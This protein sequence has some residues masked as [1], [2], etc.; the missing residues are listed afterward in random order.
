MTAPAAPASAAPAA[1]ASRQVPVA[2]V[3]VGALVPGA[4]DAAGYWRIVTGG[5]DMMTEVPAS[6]WLVADHYDPD[7]AAPDKTYARRGAFLPDVG[8]D[9]MAYGVPP[10]SLPSTDTAQL[11]ALMVADQVLTDAGGLPG[12]DRDR[13][14]VVLG[15]SAL[16]L[17]PHMYG[18]TE[19]PVWLKALRESGIGEAEAR[20]VCDRIAAHYT[21][22]RESTFPGL[23]SNVVAG[24]IAHRFDL[25]GTNHTTDAACASSLAALSTAV[26]ELALG[27]ADLVL[28]GGV[29][30]GNGIGMFLSFSKTPAL[31][32]SGDCRPLSD[33]A[34]GTML[35]EAVV[36]YALKRLSDAERDG[37]RVHAVIRGI[38]SSSDG[39]SPGIYAPLPDGQARALRRAYEEAGYGP[40]TVELVEAHGTGTPAGDTAELA[41]LNEVFGA[42]GRTDGQWCAIGSVKSQIGHTKCAAGAAGLLKAVMALH[43]K[44]LPPTIKVGRPNPAAA[45]PDGPFYV[46]TEAR[47]WVR[48]AG[49][50][51]R[52]SVSSFGFGGSNFHVTLEEYVP[53]GPS[54]R[55][56]SARGALG[57][58]AAR[59]RCAPSE[60]VLFSGASPADLVTPDTGD[61]RSLAAL[62][63]ES[64]R[65][66]AATA[67]VRLAIVA[68]DIEE[69]RE[70]H[71]RALALIRR[72]PD[73]AFSVPTGI[74][75]ASGA[76]AP[77][78]IGFLFPGQGSQYVGMGAGLAMLSPAAQSVWD[79]LGGTGFDGL[80]LHR[81]VFPPPSFTDE[82]RADRQTSLAATE[83]AQPAL[84]VHALAL[85]EVVRSLGLRPDCVAGHSFG[86]LVALHC[87]GALD[88]GSL[89]A[90]ARRRGE[91]MRDAAA[92]P[93]AM[94]AV[95]TDRAR[96]AAVLAGGGLGERGR[97]GELDGPGGPGPGAGG[98]WTANHNSPLQT[99]LSGTTEAV[100]RAERVFAAE[101]VATHRLTTSTAFHSPLVAPACEPLAA[102]LRTVPFTE[103]RIEVY[104]NADAAPYPSSPDEVR[105]RIAGHLV[106]P[107]LFQDQIEAMYAAGVRTF[108]EVGPGAAL[109]GLVGQILGDREHAAVPLDRPGRSGI[110]TLHTALGELAVRGV[111]LDLD[112]LWA[113]YASPGTAPEAESA[114]AKERGP[115][116]TVAIS[117]ANYGQPYPPLAGATGTPAAVPAAV[118]VPV[119]APVPTPPVPLPTTHHTPPEPPMYE[120]AAADAPE[121]VHDA[122]WYTAVESVQRQTA[123]AH[124]ACQRMLT[125]SH[126]AFL[127][128]TETT[129]TAMLGVRG[130]QETPAPQG[131][132][133]ITD[134]GGTDRV[135]EAAPVPA[136]PVTAPPAATAPLTLP[137][138]PA[139]RRAPAPVTPAAVE[140]PVPAPEP[141]AA[142]PVS[143]SELEEL[144][145]SV[146]ARLTGYPT[147]MLGVDME[148]EADLG[149]DSIKRVEILSAV[150]RQVGDVAAGDVSRLGKLRTLREIVEALTTGS[151]PEVPDTGSATEVP[152]PPE[153]SKTPQVTDAPALTRLVPRAVEAPAVGLAMAGL[154]DG[155]VLVTGEGPDGGGLTGLVARKLA[156]RG[157]DAT[158]VAEVPEG[159]RGVIHLGALT[160]D[161]TPDGAREVH[162]SVFRAA[163]SVAGQVHGKKGL[164]VTVQDTGGDFGLGGRA[165]GRT[166][167][168]GV[169]GLVRTA[170]KEWPGASVKAVDCERGGRDDEAVAEAIVGE[171]LEGGPATEAGLRADGT[172]VVHGAVPAPVTPGTRRRITSAS[173]IVAT[174]G[175]RGVTAAALLDLA[176]THR[177]RIVLLGRTALVPEPDGLASA[178]DEPALVRLLAERAAE[179]SAN[180]SAEKS[181][182]DS[183]A[184][185]PAPIAA[186]ITAR[187]REILAAREVRATLAALEAAGS[188]VRYIRADARDGEALGAALRE[189]RATWGPV[190]GIVH[191]AG[192]LADKLIADKTDAQVER[193]MSTKVDGLRAL[194]AATADDPLD[195]ICLFSSVAAVYGNTGQSDYAMANEI[196]GQ[197]ASAE[198]A[199][200]PGCLVRCV[201][202]GPW[203]GGMVTP[204][205]ATHFGRSGVPLIPLDRGA[206]A[207]TAEL[208]GAAGEARAILAVG[209]DPA[210]LS[211]ASDPPPA[212]L[213]VR[214]DTLPYLSDH[215][216]A[217]VPVLPV[218]MVLNWF[219]G[220]ATAWRAGTGP[221]VLRD[222]RVYKKFALPELT[223]AGHRLTVHGSRGAAGPE[224]EIETEL[225][226]A[227]GVAY[228]RAVLGTG[229]T[230]PDPAAW[231]GPYGTDGAGSAGGPYR[232]GGPDSE[233]PLDRAGI[234]D[235]ELLFHGPRFQAVRTLHALSAHG[236]EATVAGL[237][238][239]G[240][241]GDHWPLD[242]AAVD[243][244]L[245]LALLWARNAAGTATLP[246]AVAECRVHRRGPVDGTVRCVVRGRKT[247]STGA[248]CDA[249]LIDADGAVR[250][251]L[252]GVELVSRPS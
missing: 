94:L 82:E 142:A 170:A 164:F 240:W 225:R 119:A 189:V 113:P 125:D 93:G 180:E 89:V 32:R 110:S 246:M 39:R 126:I 218:A 66:F 216:L 54:G 55:D 35:G 17:L 250:L 157:V 249:A 112:P 18:R 120:T 14:G 231:H 198:Q 161:G 104:G 196:L 85:L 152:E 127:R 200:R 43:H 176:R 192:V 187:A 21:P 210:A 177:P 34:D 102:F 83:W 149:V 57:R 97:P 75:Y 145:L 190:T 47:P 63:R 13:I 144:L 129:L 3:G 4:T 44:V 84:A 209:D 26:G 99:V 188:L 172:R 135:I 239:L 121:P 22:W 204:A 193:V 9:P 11:L 219:A 27:R 132:H 5:R 130:G 217:G 70:K 37:D 165:A 186:R 154:L 77:G 247:H 123:E 45:S 65:A 2:V 88:A 227:D 136:A 87:A 147:E 229:S 206:A 90:L 122:D 167:L 128:M 8:F 28:S 173:V 242:P 184:S 64:Q 79:E 52:A 98:L 72:R 19:R 148:L 114:Q 211:P 1:P 108:V 245:Q 205:L 139:P 236:A 244:A 81:V 31:S 141:A 140:V 197:V 76:P 25:H 233:E 29:D 73:A 168:G 7:P 146:V 24:R 36:M 107:V 95:A 106:S 67:P 159:A 226:G 174:G 199:A 155:P 96:V 207:F 12:M 61:G 86:E 156:E 74:R 134:Q 91:L 62:A 69:L 237:R 42:S 131:L 183:T 224:A 33:A 59:H 169:A 51:R 78:R 151:N 23:L 143:A 214:A 195:V 56:A 115:R 118:P 241:P 71:T 138:P 201:A 16:E 179:E 46:N 53:A 221:L 215:T 235:G 48:P 222:L 194:L 252:L 220:A 160:G 158:A 150:R 191:G 248:R 109:S 15:V 202:W 10:T 92:A 203:R 162:R 103:P 124:A 50:P 251:E 101:R 117:G 20:A 163:R 238:A 166:W 181:A 228:F 230:A 185:S 153:A 60:L 243:G 171:L 213:L 49:H 234:Y 178:A 137:R 111:P 80:P 182:T 105:R 116:M 175:A 232:T 208:D 38:G 30:T 100:E 133:G 223:G 212:Q 40:E 68:T 6:R 58:V 41:A